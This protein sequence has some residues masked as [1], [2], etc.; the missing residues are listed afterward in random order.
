[1]STPKNRILTGLTQARD[2]VLFPREFITE[3]IRI[4]TARHAQ[5]IV[6][7]HLTATAKQLPPHVFQEGFHLRGLI[8]LKQLLRFHV[9]SIARSP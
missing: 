4:R 3:M 6:R 8:T 7:G 2:A 9:K 5:L 1:M